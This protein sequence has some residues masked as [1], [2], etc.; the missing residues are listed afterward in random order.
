[1]TANCLHPG[2]V[3][4][5]FGSADDTSGVERLS[6]V[7]SSPFSIS[8]ARGARTIVY[9]ASSPEVAARTGGYYV[10]DRQHRPSKAARDDVAA[11][12][13]WET[14]EEL[15]ASVPA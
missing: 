5:G 15:I 10:R 2:V 8:A 6:M 12:Q 11:K 14:S 7:V 1:V 3:R 13:L 4:T 9:L